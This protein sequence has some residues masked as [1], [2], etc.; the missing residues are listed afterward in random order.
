M[1]GSLRYLTRAAYLLTAGLV[2]TLLAG[3]ELSTNGGTTWS[4]SAAPV[5]LAPTSNALGSTTI[6]VRLDTATTGAVGGSITHASPGTATVSGN[7]LAKAAPQSG[8]LI[9]WPLTR[10]AQD[11]PAIRSPRL[12]ATAPTLKALYLANGTTPAYF[13]KFG[14]ALGAASNGDGT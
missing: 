8:P 1:R 5:T 4:G 3:F 2:I 10:N 9:W 14:Q 12:V 7:R 13:T 11:R 6:S